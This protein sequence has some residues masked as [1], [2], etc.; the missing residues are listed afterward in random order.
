MDISNKTLFFGGIGFVVVLV[1][2]VI[3]MHMKKDNYN[4]P[5]GTLYDPIPGQMA[6]VIGSPTTTLN[7]TYLNAIVSDSSG[8]ISTS[9]ALPTG[10]IVM[11]AGTIDDISFLEG[12]W[13]LCDGTNG[14]PDL[15]SRFI[16]GANTSQSATSNMTNL[17]VYPQNQ[18]GG[19]EYHQLI[20]SE[21]PSH[22]HAINGNPQGG[23]TTAGNANLTAFSTY[24]GADALTG[25][26]GGDYPHNNLPPYYALAF[27][28]KMM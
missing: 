9:A 24:G 13:S 8:N 26:S 14:T 11:W 17:N 6:T 28:M 21:M 25:A 23:L 19:E 7:K 20:V 4:Y 2:V 22:T 27:I 5:T 16:I 10:A 12:Y 3:I 18:I 1:I 15:R